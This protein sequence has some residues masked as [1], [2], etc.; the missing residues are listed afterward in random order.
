[1]TRIMPQMAV[2]FMLDMK[3]SLDPKN[4]FAINNTIYSSELEEKEDNETHKHWGIQM[5]P[6]MA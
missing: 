2:D 4:I 5:L 1:M 3:K 6:K